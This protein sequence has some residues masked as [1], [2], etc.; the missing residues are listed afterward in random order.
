MKLKMVEI[1][2]DKICVDVVVENVLDFSCGQFKLRFDTNKLELGTITSPILLFRGEEEKGKIDINITD[3]H[4]EFRKG[5]SV[6]RIT[7]KPL[8]LNLSSIPIDFIT[9]DLR[10]TQP[11]HIPAN[12]V[13]R[14]T[15]PTDLTKAYCYP[16]PY[17]HSKY[18][19]QG[20]T[21]ADLTEDVRIKIFTI[22]GELVYDSGMITSVSPGTFKWHATNQSNK[23]LASGIYIYLITNNQGEKK[24][25]K[26]GIM[27]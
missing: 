25:G 5:G 19:Q 7:F 6:V 4:S 14:I 16:N 10:D 27:R 15:F 2:E 22:A 18:S 9:V 11:A 8:I 3:L 24:I 21:F 20:I 13:P 26:I 12:I 23:P 17:I 1:S